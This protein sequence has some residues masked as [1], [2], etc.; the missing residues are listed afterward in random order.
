M[1][2]PLAIITQQDL[3]LKSPLSSLTKHS[4][5]EGRPNTT[6]YHQPMLRNSH[7][8]W[9]TLPRP[10]HHCKTDEVRHGINCLLVIFVS[11]EI[12]YHGAYKL[13]AVCPQLR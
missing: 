4:A 12:L 5:N 8:K 1:K 9:F 6:F 11:I 13:E 2:V 10:F 3:D 7:N